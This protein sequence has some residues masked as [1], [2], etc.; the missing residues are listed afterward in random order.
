M[1]EPYTCASV[2]ILCCV[3][4]PTHKNMYICVGLRALTGLQNS[5][6]ARVC[7]HAVS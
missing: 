3:N 6:F 4:Q 1:L 7:T 5:D 2:L